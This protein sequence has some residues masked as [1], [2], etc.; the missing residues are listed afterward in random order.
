MRE[1]LKRRQTRRRTHFHD[2]N[3]IFVEKRV[4]LGQELEVNAPLIQFVVFVDGE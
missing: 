2:A 1:L 4:W 3:V